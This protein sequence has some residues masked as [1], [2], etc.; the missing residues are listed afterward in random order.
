MQKYQS[1]IVIEQLLKKEC[2]SR[3]WCLDR[4]II[5]LG[6]IVADLVAD[7]W[8]F[9]DYISK[10]GHDTIRGS[11]VKGDY[12]YKLVSSPIIK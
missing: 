4:R 10:T 7:G 3:N 5:R 2:V 1:Q 6:A 11:Y 12:V 8:K 9:D